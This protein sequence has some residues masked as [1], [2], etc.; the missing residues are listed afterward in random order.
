MDV[1]I[2]SN[3]PG[4]LRE[5]RDI[6]APL[7]FAVYSQ[8]EKGIELEPEETGAAFEENAYIKAR[9]VYDIARCPVIADDSGLMVDALGGEPGVYS[10]RYK[11]LKTE[12]ERRLAILKGL[13][14]ADDR[15]ARFVCC[16][17]YID[18]SGEAHYFTGI[19]HGAIALEESGENGFGYDPIFIAENA[20]GRT[21]ASL[22]ITFKE[23]HSHRAKAVRLLMEYLT[24]KQKA[25]LS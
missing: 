4:K 11:G 23:T 19:W 16:I 8:R 13:E 17:C 14:G 6:L 15:G 21:T 2:A 5:Y 12:H 10:A 20:G 22:P 25:A 9:A 24:G 18:Q 3:N 1:I 7:G